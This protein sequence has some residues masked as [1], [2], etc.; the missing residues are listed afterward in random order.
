MLLRL[1]HFSLNFLNGLFRAN[2]PVSSYV[3]CVI[4]AP[5][6][7]PLSFVEKKVI[8]RRRRV[9]R[10]KTDKKLKRHLLKRKKVEAV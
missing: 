8:E 1:R 9:D 4:Y 2:V 6:E 7:P 5:R 3:T 10:E